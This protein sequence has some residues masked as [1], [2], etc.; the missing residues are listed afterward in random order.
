MKFD[1]LHFALLVAIV[2]LAVYVARGYGLFRE[3]LWCAYPNAAPGK[4]CCKNGGN[5]QYCPR[6]GTHFDEAWRYLCEG[7]GH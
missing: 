2:L 7:W 4:R 3:G 5:C 6:G 1:S